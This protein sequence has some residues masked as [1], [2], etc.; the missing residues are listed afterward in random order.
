MILHLDGSRHRSF[1]LS[2]CSDQAQIGNA[3]H[4]FGEHQALQDQYNLPYEDYY[5]EL[6]VKR[7]PD[8]HSYYSKSI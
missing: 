5:Y 2:K 7:I 6:A 4:A 1:Q 3:T 8:Y